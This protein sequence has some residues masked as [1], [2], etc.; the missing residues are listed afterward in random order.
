VI[1]ARRFSEL[2]RG[3]LVARL[4]GDEFVGLLDRPGADSQRLHEAGRILTT[5]LA[6]P[7]VLP[8]AGVTVTASVGLVSTRGPADLH[9]CSPMYRA[10]RYGVTLADRPSPELAVGVS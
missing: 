5:A 4:G 2:A 1:V 8:E 3:G 6:A 9:D 7:I 10:R